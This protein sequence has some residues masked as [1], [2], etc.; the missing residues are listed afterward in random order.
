M[1]RVRLKKPQTKIGVGGLEISDYEKQLVNEVLNSNQLTYG[2]V[3]KKFEE[4]FAKLHDCKF[5]LFMNSGTSVLHV[6]LASF[7]AMYGWHDGDEVLVP[8]VTFVATSNIVLHNKLTPIFVDVEPLT[9]NIDWTKIEEKITSKTRAIIPVHLLGLPATM[10][11]ILELSKKNNLTIIEDS[12]E[13]MFA[14]YNGRKVGSLGDMASFSTYVAHVLVTGV[15][16][17]A[18]TSDPDLAVTMRSLMNHGR[19]S[20]Y[21]SCSDDEGL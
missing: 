20:I 4:A 7:K 9:Y 15:G 6:A 21:I 16:G 14:T 11:P 19:D 10:D 1:L 3:T 18:T 8:S 5:A 17:L 2:P 12:C 13:T